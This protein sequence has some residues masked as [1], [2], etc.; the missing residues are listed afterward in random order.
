MNLS[1]VDRGPPFFFKIG[2]KATLDPHLEPAYPLDPD[3]LSWGLLTAN[4][5]KR[6]G[7]RGSMELLRW[8][9]VS[10][11]VASER[12]LDKLAYLR[13]SYVDETGRMG[14]RLAK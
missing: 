12:G 10:N 2:R 14:T 6:G 11:E 1:V 4:V 3:L 9:H 5:E 13:T 7:T 8:W